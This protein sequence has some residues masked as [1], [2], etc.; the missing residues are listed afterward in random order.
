MGLGVPCAQGQVSEKCPCQS[1]DPCLPST[2]SERTVLDHDHESRGQP[3][4]HDCPKH[5]PANSDFRMGQGRGWEMGLGGRGTLPS[6]LGSAGQSFTTDSLLHPQQKG[7]S[8][9]TRHRPTI[10]LGDKLLCA[11]AGAEAVF[12]NVK[13]LH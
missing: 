9:H 3:S 10:G 7:L 11:G 13:L 6:Q 4:G 12:G 5:M 1:E 8:G 2:T